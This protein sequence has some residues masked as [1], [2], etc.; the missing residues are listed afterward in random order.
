MSLKINK[1]KNIQNGALLIQANKE[2]I[3][4][5]EAEIK[6][7]MQQNYEINIP[8]IKKPRIL[9]VGMKE[10]INDSDLVRAIKCQN[11][12]GESEITCVS[13]YKSPKTN[14]YSAIIEVDSVAYAKV[15]EWSRLC[16]GWDYCRVYPNYRVLRCFKCCGYNHLAKYCEKDKVCVK[17]AGNHDVLECVS[18]IQKCVNCCATKLRLNLDIN[19][20]HAANDPNCPTFA[21]KIKVAKEQVEG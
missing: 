6:N 21:R 18:Q 14:C 2:S 4:K 16:I 15:L 3:Q 12:L 13:I 8:T 10:V 7:K 19:T 5:I 20:N 11:Q 1:V 17:C 9:I